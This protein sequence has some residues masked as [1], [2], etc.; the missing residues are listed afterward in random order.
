VSISLVFALLSCFVCC[1]YSFAIPARSPGHSIG[2]ST[3]PIHLEMFADWQ[4]ADSRASWPIV[5]QV[6]K[7]FG[8]N[9][10]Y[11]T[12]HILQLWFFRQT[13]DIALAAETIAQ[14]SK[15]D[16][17]DLATY[18][19]NVQP[20]YYNNVWLYKTQADLYA[21]LAQI[22]LLYGVDNTTFYQGIT[23]FEEGGIWDIVNTAHVYAKTQQR[24]GTPTFMVNGFKDATLSEKNYI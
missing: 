14:N 20:N 10:V 13:G 7:S 3:A 2:N 4:C 23:Q 22:G 1:S 9:Q 11:F 15:R 24:P 6:V 8:P 19:F 16:Y 21:S 12:L 17:W 18:L 5:S